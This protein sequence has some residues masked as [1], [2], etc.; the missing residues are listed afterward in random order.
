MYAPINF[1]ILYSVQIRNDVLN[2][3]VVF[4]FQLYKVHNITNLRSVEKNFNLNIRNLSLNFGVSI[5]YN[6]I[7][8]MYIMCLYVG[9]YDIL[10]S[11]QIMSII[12]FKMLQIQKMI[13][14]RYKIE[15]L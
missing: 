1:V 11:K 4:V 7:C 14:T 15:I 10:I 5:H 9:F 8:F 13:I 12:Y 2:A 6:I 3:C